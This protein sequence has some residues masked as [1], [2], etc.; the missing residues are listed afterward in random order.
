MIR[1]CTWGQNI[2]CSSRGAHRSSVYGNHGWSFRK[3]S[4]SRWECGDMTFIIFYFVEKVW[5]C[6]NHT[7]EPTSLK[8]KALHM[9]WKDPP[10]TI[11][12]WRSHP[13]P[14]PLP[15]VTDVG[16]LGFVSHRCLHNSLYLHNTWIEMNYIALFCIFSSLKQMIYDT[17]SCTTSF[18]HSTLY[19]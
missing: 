13:T 7:S 1:C 10:H 12:Q 19:L 16:H 3:P 18:F 6:Y 17:H 9:N 2:G 4:T 14:P 11:L 15:R 5:E 8:R